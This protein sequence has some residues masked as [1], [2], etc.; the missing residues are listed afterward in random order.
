MSPISPQYR[1]REIARVTC[2]RAFAGRASIMSGV[3]DATTLTAATL[4]PPAQYVTIWN[5]AGTSQFMVPVGS[6]LTKSTTDPTKVKVYT[7][8]G[9]NANDVQTVSITGTPTGGTFTLTFNGQTTAGIAQNAT[10]AN[11]ITAL[12]ALPNIGAAANIAGTGGG[13]P[14]TPVVLTFGGLL[15][16]QP[17]NLMTANGAGLTGGT[18]PAVTVTHTTPGTSAE[19]IIGVFD[20]PDQDFFGNASG[21]DVPIPIYFHSCSF[22]ITKLQNWAAFG[23]AAETALNSCTFY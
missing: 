4:N 16:N 18:T 23:A 12:T 17:Q 5:A 3:F 9:T 10:A 6:F 8:A 19:K 22:D 1:A 7:G 20:G 13:L 2:L 15:G 21:D 14:G 11:V